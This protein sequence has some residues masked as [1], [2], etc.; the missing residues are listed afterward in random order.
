MSRAYNTLLTRAQEERLHLLMEECG[1]TVQAASKVLRHGYASVNP[2]RYDTRRDNRMDLEKECGH[3]RHSMIR[4]CE[5]GDLNRV[6]I[7][8]AAEAKAT[9]VEQWL[10]FQGSATI[11]K[12]DMQNELLVSLKAVVAVADRNTVEFE[13]ARAVIAKAEGR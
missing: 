2:L 12:S 5:A 11:S 3:V 13:R 10:H 4:L 9:E 1:E 7:H 6:A 8:D